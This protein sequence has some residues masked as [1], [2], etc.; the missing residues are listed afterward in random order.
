MFIIREYILLNLI[1]PIFKTNFG[2]FYFL[3]VFLLMCH[4]FAWACL[5]H[6]KGEEYWKALIPIYSD[7]VKAKT[8]ECEKFFTS[9]VIYIIVSFV[10]KMC[11]KFLY[12]ITTFKTIRFIGFLV[13][14]AIPFFINLLLIFIYVRF[15]ICVGL[16]HKTSKWFI[17]GLVIF[18][19]LFVL[20]LAFE[21]P[22]K[23]IFDKLK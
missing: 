9:S 18:E 3:N 19:P 10:F 11:G 16:K 7:Y 20:F 13:G 6:K 15:F 12:S 14:G 17:L 23:N 21:K 1:N 8:Y 4:T 2:N 5:F 22:I